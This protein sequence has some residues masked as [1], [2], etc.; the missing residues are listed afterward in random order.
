MSGRVAAG[1]VFRNGPTVTVEVEGL[2]VGSTKT[3]GGGYYS[4]NFL[5]PEPIK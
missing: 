5:T 2:V 4:I 3:S 1:L